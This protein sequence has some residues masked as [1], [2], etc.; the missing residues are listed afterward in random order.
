MKLIRFVL[1]EM[2]VSIE[3]DPGERVIDMLRERFHLTGAKESCG[4][5]EC[6]S[7]TIL[8][9]DIAVHSCMLL[10]HQIEGCRLTTVEGLERE[11]IMDSLQQAF[12]DHGAIQC[13]FCTPGMLISAKALLLRNPNPTIEEIEAALE[14]NL[15]RCTGYKKIIEAVHSVSKEGIHEVEHF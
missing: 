6:G 3:A 4:Q 5:G 13:G 9:N 7:C 14:G 2:E 15:C 8:L 12:V 10:V 1:N 11:E